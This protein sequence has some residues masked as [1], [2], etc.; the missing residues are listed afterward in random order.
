VLGGGHS[1]LSPQYGLGIDSM[2]LNSCR[3]LVEVA[4]NSPDVVQFEIVTPDSE[5]RIVNAHQNQDLFWAL[6]G[7]GSGFGV[8][9]S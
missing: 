8:I 4:N 5:L 3:R 9:N 2:S 7:G 1:S 6:R